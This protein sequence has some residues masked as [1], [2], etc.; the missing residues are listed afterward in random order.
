MSEEIS[1]LQIR[2]LSDQVDVARKR[3][4][5]LENQGRKTESRV[6]SFGTS[7]KVALGAVGISMAGLTAVVGTSTREWLKYDVAMKE[8]A[9]ISSQS[10]EEFT[11][12][13][14]D[15]LELASAMGVD[16]T[17]AANGLYQ[18]LSAGVPKENAIEFLKVASQAAVAGVSDVKTAVD[19]LTN[20]INAYKIPV[21]EAETVSD[22]LFATVVDGKTTFEEL[23][24]SMSKA[25]VPAA[26]M[27]VSLDELLASVIS[28]TKQGTP[29]AEAFTQI[30]ATLTAL[31]N[32]S[33]EMSTAL[34]DIG[35]ESSK[36]AIQALGF[37][38]T[39]E[40][41][42]NSFN[43]NDSAMVK[44]FRSTEALGG[45]LSQ[46][47]VNLATFK[48]GLDNVS[49][50]AGASSKAFKTN[51]ETLQNSMASMKAAFVSL[52]ETFEG[53]F[54]ILSETARLIKDVS[55]A[56]SQSQGVGAQIQSLVDTGG[57]NAAAQLQTRLTDLQEKEKVLRVTL[58]RNK[59]SKGDLALQA[60]PL[61]AILPNETIDS[62]KSL[63]LVQKQIAETKQALEG[64]GSTYN[65]MGQL[66]LALADATANGNQ[67]AIDAINAQ[68]EAKQLLI[69]KEA[70]ISAILNRDANLRKADDDSRVKAAAE[71]LEMQ[72]AEAKLLDD[73]SKEAKKLSITQTEILEEKIKGFELLKAS[74]PEEAAAAQEAIDSLK[75]QIR[76]LD[77]K[78]AKKS[79]AASGPLPFG[80][81]DV[82]VSEE[83]NITQSYARRQES[84]LAKMQET[85][86]RE[87]Q[88]AIDATKKRLDEEERLES[89]YRQS[90][91]DSTFAF[92]GDLA[93]IQ[94]A[95]GEKG[96]KIAQGAAVAQATM[97][98]FEAAQSAY[99]AGAAIPGIGI[100]AG[101][102]FAAA[103]LAAGAANIASIKSQTYQAY[104]QGGYIP[105]GNVGIVGE[106]GAEFVRGP[107]VVTSANATRG[108]RGSGEASRGLQI[109]INNVPG[110][111]VETKESPD[112]ETIEFTIRKT[113]DRLASEA[114]NGGGKVFP[115]FAKT[116]GL[117]RKA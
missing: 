117:K 8:V 32:P 59:L 111:E 110:H 89:V 9:S 48:S 100:I 105:P 109:V 96:F 36:A 113:M 42:R 43:G 112:G 76:L 84:I 19:G 95:F 77:E 83:E 115:T 13:R 82:L 10:R 79:G 62:L 102:T 35:F 50:S 4:D 34:Q 33:K 39:L 58:E 18:A 3:L 12:M 74:R 24:R 80:L 90:T 67:S 27:G 71:T 81:S 45:V 99:A 49:N 70:D 98:M 93:S 106:S 94:G 75:E 68:I 88:L 64:L 25:T 11:Q 66:Q 46:T 17:V 15:V 87:G 1:T 40:Q 114:A 55:L 54:H 51:A 28:I 60:T 14:S 69:T 107:A 85:K 16:A 47:G 41:L 53:N 116:H 91:F 26:A 104:A 5:S 31:L 78:N 73:L 6:K 56:I 30:K 52:V 7:A 23:S 65:E 72:K 63:T 57:A 2:V 61:G 29:T 37:G 92:F 20:V 103:A 44:A 38:E 22:K 97:K 101:P 86:D 108:Q 21:S